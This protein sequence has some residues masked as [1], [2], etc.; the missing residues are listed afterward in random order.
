MKYIITAIADINIIE[1]EVFIDDKG[2]SVETF[3]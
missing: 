3:R 1:P 2:Y